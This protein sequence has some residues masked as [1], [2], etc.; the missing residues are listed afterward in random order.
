MFGYCSPYSIK[1]EITINK[2]I[3]DLYV[4]TDTHK[5]DSVVWNEPFSFFNAAPVLLA[6]WGRQR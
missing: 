2:I 5:Q 4:I 6:K 1:N 3:I